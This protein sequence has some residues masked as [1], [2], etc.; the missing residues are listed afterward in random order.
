[1]GD[2]VESFQRAQILNVTLQEGNYLLPRHALSQFM[3]LNRHRGPGSPRPQQRQQ[4][5]CDEYPN[6]PETHLPMF[7]QWKHE[8]CMNSVP[9]GDVLACRYRHST[10]RLFSL[11]LS[12][13]KAAGA[14]PGPV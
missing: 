11:S 8:V 7:S 6:N 5:H 4:E 9:K 2:L 10:G 14:P 1:M 12:V 3:P 13:L